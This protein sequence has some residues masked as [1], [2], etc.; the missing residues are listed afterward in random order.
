MA[1]VKVFQTKRGHDDWNTLTDILKDAGVYVSN[2]AEDAD[3]SIVISGKF[4][5]T[6]S[7]SGKK[8]LAYN[9]YEWLRNVPMP[10]GFNMYKFILD[11]YYDDFIDLT[12]L[13]VEDCAKK[14]LDYIGG[15]DV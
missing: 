6:Q 15:L 12:N 13:S 7:L 8:V 1:N 5:N 2:V 9:A 10:M 14:I 3:V 4:V 11:E